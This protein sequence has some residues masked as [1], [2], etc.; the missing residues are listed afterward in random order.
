MEFA[1]EELVAGFDVET[2][3]P[4]YPNLVVVESL[5]D[6]CLAVMQEMVDYLAL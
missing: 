2:S 3:A 4:D 5:E 1:T 6:N